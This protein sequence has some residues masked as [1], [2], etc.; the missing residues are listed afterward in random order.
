MNTYVRHLIRRAAT[1]TLIAT[2]GLSACAVAPAD[3]NYGDKDESGV[4]ADGKEDRWDYR[5]DPSRF[6]GE[7]NYHLEDLPLEGRAEREAWPSTYWPTYEDSINHRWQRDELS[8]AEKYDRAFNGWEPSED[9]MELRPFNRSR[10]APTDSWDPEYYEQLGPLASLISNRMGNKG[11][12]DIAVRTGGLPD[13]DAD[14]GEWAT[15]TWFGLCHAWVPASML[16][17]RPERAVTHNGVTFEVGDMEALLI[18]AYNRAPADMIG[19]RCNL[20]N[21]DD[22]KVERDEQGRATATECRD[23]NPG[24]FHVI[25]SNYLGIMNRPYAEDRTYDYQVWNQPVVAFEV[26]K[27][28]KIDVAKANELLTVDGDEYIYNPDAESLYEVHASTTYITESS[29]STTPADASRYERTDTYTYILEIDA[30]GKIIGGEWF[31]RSQASLP[32]FLWSPKRIERSSVRNLDIN[33]IRM[34]VQMSREPEVPDVP[35]DV[36]EVLGQANVAIPDN[37]AAGAKSTAVV[38][39]SAE[40]G[41]VQVEVAIG[42]TYIGDLT[43][44]LHHGDHQRVVHNREGGGQDDLRKT[45]NVPG[46]TG[47]D[48]AGDW[49]LEVVD[50]AGQDVGTIEGWT[51]RITPEGDGGTDPGDGGGTTDGGSFAGHG[52]MPIPDNDDG[53]ITSVA[54]VAAGTTGTTTQ[55]ALNIT[56]PYVGDLVIALTSPT[57]QQWILQERTGGNADDINRTFA[58]D[59]APEGAL[60]GD[61]KLG[62]SDRAGRDTGTLNSWSLNI[63]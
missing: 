36:I 63:R 59:P 10:P 24:S 44:T 43:V 42:H 25:M 18:A 33:Q 30:E 8:P 28:E 11:D 6:D 4:F 35:G 32:D 50:S 19:G 2:L 38:A 12:R 23:T 60:E 46:F 61:W 34:L 20:G 56:H 52:N 57:G 58:L 41:S 40:V 48:A 45:F 31:G 62:V 55:V 47:A 54:E 3:G 14:D 29:A 53:G 13:V 49:V 21:D 9:F 7:L 22:N 5:N 39:E 27:M 17:E 16:E 1:G 51:L 26:T 15:E 37:D